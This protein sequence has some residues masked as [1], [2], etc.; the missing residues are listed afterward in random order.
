MK[1]VSA[2]HANPPP[3]TS[4]KPRPRLSITVRPETIAVLDQISEIS[5]L[6]KTALCGRMLDD[7]IPVFLAL[8]D[9]F[10]AIKAGHSGDA[11]SALQAM[12]TDLLRDVATFH[13][14]LEKNKSRRIKKAREPNS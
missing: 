7:S 8:R 13:L 2:K 1:P 4:R 10:E 5:G 9:V 6:S 14:E 12:N 11:V 3:V